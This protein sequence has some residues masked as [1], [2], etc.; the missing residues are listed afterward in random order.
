VAAQ[1]GALRLA[2]RVERASRRSCIAATACSGKPPLLHCGDG[3]LD[4][5]E[6]CDA[7][8]GPYASPAIELRSNGIIIELP[9]V[10]G[11]PSAEEFYDY[12]DGSGHTGNE[13]IAGTKLY[14]YRQY[15]ERMLSL[16]VHHGIDFEATGFVQPNGAAVFSISELP[17]SSFVSVSDDAGEVF[18]DTTTSVF[19]KWQ[20]GQETDGCVIGGIPFPGRWHLFVQPSFLMGIDSFTALSG[21]GYRTGLALAETVELIASDEPGGCRR[22]CTLPRCGDGRLDPGELCD[23]GNDQFLDGCTHCEYDY[24]DTLPPPR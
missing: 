10:L 7:G 21:D 23:D 13:N 3:V 19:A 17:D 8:E 15:S 24:F 18:K 20:F 5:G 12:H 2:T 4:R 22:D 14:F 16:I 9:P 6:E 1:A 11:S